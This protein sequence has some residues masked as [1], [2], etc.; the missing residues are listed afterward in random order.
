MTSNEFPVLR[1]CKTLAAML[2]NGTLK[3]NTLTRRKNIALTIFSVLIVNLLT[4][5]LLLPYAQKTANSHMD[6][7]P[8]F[9]WSYYIFAVLTFVIGIK[10]FE[11]T[12]DKIFLTTMIL[13]LFSFLY[14]GHKL[15]S[16]QCIVCLNSG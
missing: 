3:L 15:N 12:R 14:L 5:T 10:Y 7:G 2:K 4:L 16:L 13:L 11:K 9:G 6:S 8:F 1:Q